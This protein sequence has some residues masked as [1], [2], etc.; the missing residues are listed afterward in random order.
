MISNVKLTKLAPQGKRMIEWVER[1][2]PVLMTI[3]KEMSR[4]KPLKKLRVG[5]ALHIEAKTAALVR[6]LVA[7]GAEVALAGCNPLSTRD[8]V[9]AALLEDGINV[10]AWRGQSE[11]D[12]YANIHR[13]L[14]HRP[15]V[16]IDD[17]ADLISTTHAK[18]PEQIRKIRGACEETTT[19]VNRLRI[20]AAG[21]ALKFPV[22]AVNDSPAKHLFDNRFGTAESALQGI[23]ATTNT[24]IAGKQ[25]VVVGYGFVGRG[26]ASR[27][28]GLGAIVTVVETDPIRALE[29]TM[30]GFRV[31]RMAEAA[32]IG[33]IFITTTGNINVIRKEHMK[34]M[35]D[36]AILSNAGHFNIEIDLK[37]LGALAVVQRE[38]M[39]DIKEFRLRD[40]RRLYLLTEGR[41]VNLAGK[42]S[43]GHPMEIMDMSFSLQALCVTYLADHGKKFEPKVYEVPAEIDRKVAEL[44]L[45]SLGIRLER[46]TLEQRKY[47][48]SWKFGT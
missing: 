2:M 21:G 37:G 13:V 10:Y 11:K 22:I 12:Y 8:E 23:M 44:K 43:L 32:R 31:A 38:V 18:R 3:R 47:L 9:V 42:R 48:E 19:G 30:D 24:L 41:L 35:K 36:G 7:G 5:A 34:K 16:L 6:T 4:Q 25:I 39:D 14:D 20:M 27:A 33:D 46:P 26:I 40:G 15:D 29:A 17:G 1:H 28:K 45:R